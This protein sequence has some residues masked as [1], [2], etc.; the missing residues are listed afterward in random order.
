[1][2]DLSMLS[3]YGW[4]FRFSLQSDDT[5]FRLF[6]FSM[7]GLGQLRSS[8]QFHVLIHLCLTIST[9]NTSLYLLFLSKIAPWRAFS[10][11]SCNQASLWWSFNITYKIK[12]FCSSC[13]Q[14]VSGFYSMSSNTSVLIINTTLH[15]Y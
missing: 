8:R 2:L 10:W 7:L 6:W 13:H 5:Y 9:S 11:R 3:Q 14:S 12:F 15:T 4:Q 1:M